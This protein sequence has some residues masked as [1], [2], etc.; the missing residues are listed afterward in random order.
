MPSILGNETKFNEIPADYDKWR[1]TYVPE[2]YQDILDFK[3]INK[4]SNVLEIGI[5]TGQATLPF[6]KTNCH[7]KAIELGDKLAE[8]SKQK[9]K[10]H[11]NFEVHNISFQDF[12]GLDQSFDMIYSATAFHWI[13]AEIGYPKVYNLLKSGGVFARFANHPYKDKGN[14]A[15][16]IA[17]QKV[18]SKYMSYAPAPPEYGKE[19]CGE[20][21]NKMQEYG[22]IDVNYKLYQRTRTFKADEY[23]SLINTYSD[24]R[25]MDE[26]KRNKF[27]NE[28]IDEINKH[29]GNITVYDTI[30][31]Q[32]ARKP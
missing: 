11:K 12:E 10:E 29:G 19:Q 24:H 6:L 18:Y 17:I 31:L 26:E 5:G 32:L 22:F 1:P 20:I 4:S 13:P 30:D 3:D 28:I 16:D 7:L 14:E 23:I 21:A 25:A 27:Y 8:Y 9:F 15:L 2:L